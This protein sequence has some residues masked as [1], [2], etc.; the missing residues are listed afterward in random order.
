[1]AIPGHT[2]NWQ[3]QFD[4]K[5]YFWKSNSIQ[6][7]WY[8]FES[9][10]SI[11]SQKFID[12]SRELINS[13]QNELISWSIWCYLHYWIELGAIIWSKTISFWC[14]Q[15]G[16]I[17]RSRLIHDDHSIEYSFCILIHDNCCTSCPFSKLMLFPDLEPI[18]QVK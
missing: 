11:E 4:V 5:F 9:S 15:F 3:L 10:K 18:L 6:K 1:M 17:Y 8:V 2:S 14:F 16:R 12:Q 7:F 13:I